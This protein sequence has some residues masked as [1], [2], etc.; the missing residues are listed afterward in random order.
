MREI[1]RLPA[2][3][4]LSFLNA[5]QLASLLSQPMTSPNTNMQSRNSDVL[6][7]SWES[8]T[9]IME[10]GDS[11]ATIIC[12]KISVMAACHFVSVQVSFKHSSL[13][14]TL[15]CRQCYLATRLL[16]QSSWLCFPLNNITSA[17]FSFIVKCD[18]RNMRVATDEPPFQNNSCLCN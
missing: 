8:D 16:C 1:S 6:L 12:S 4:D 13:V 18:K 10:V 2:T 9:E 3:T 7:A 17:A 11:R 14:R 15:S 5:E